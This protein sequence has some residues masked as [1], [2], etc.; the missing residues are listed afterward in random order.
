MKLLRLPLATVARWVARAQAPLALKLRAGLLL[1]IAMV[2][3]TGFLSVSAFRRIERQAVELEQLH[4][5]VTLAQ[6][7]LDRSIVVQEGLSSMLVL[8]GDASY[9]AKLIAERRRFRQALAQL[10][11]HEVAKADVRRIAEVFARYEQASEAVAKTKRQGLDH[12]AQDL[13]TTLERVIAH[14]IETSTGAL[15]SGIQG[16]RQAEL[17]RILWDQHRTKWI[18][19]GSFLLSIVLALA[20]ASLIARSIVHPIRRVDA[21]LERIARGEFTI[22]TDVANRD[23]LGSLVAHLNRMSRQLAELYTREREAAR[24]LHEQFESLRRTQAQLVQAEKL[25]ALGEMAGGVAH[26]FN[27]LLTV[28]LG[29]AQVLLKKGTDGG[30]G[31]AELERRL[32]VVE[33]AALDG[34]NTVRRLLEF[35][36]A[37]PRLHEFEP[38]LV[39]DLFA[40][41]VAAAQPRWKDEANAQ[42]R[43]IE[44]VTDFREVPPILGNPAELREVLLNLIFNALDAM[45]EGGRLGLRAWRDGD[46]VCLAVGDTGVGMPEEVASRVFEPFFTTKP[47]GTGLGLSLTHQIVTQHGGAIDVESQ[48]PAG[49]TVRLS[50]PTRRPLAAA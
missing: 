42:G 2:I 16:H 5:A 11:T 43:Q 44:V 23:E 37:R 17:A 31:A 6:A 28:V 9:H 48:P 32:G 40:S 4:S 12:Y 1:V 8:T 41:V 49:T 15:V 33:Q 27:N 18:V 47:D 7:E 13:H 14:E 24:K 36:R 19:G 30:V 39:A 50:L 10:A 35:T 38:I 22:V 21:T 3:A 25:R 26:D 20:L 29:Q 34:A 45:P 46:A